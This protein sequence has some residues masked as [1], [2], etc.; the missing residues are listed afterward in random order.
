MG[1][2]TPDRTNGDLLAM[3][4]GRRRYFTPDDTFGVTP[5]QLERLSRARQ[6]E[7]MTAWFA[8][9][10]EDPA[11]STPYNSAEGGYLFIWGGPYDAKDELFNEFGSTIPE[12]RIDEAVEEVTRDGI[13]DWAPG[14]DHPDRQQAR[15]EALW[16]DRP[17]FDDEETGRPTTLGPDLD[18]II[19]DLKGGARPRY[20]GPLDAALRR[21]I[22]H[23]LDELKSL[24]EPPKPAHGGIGHNRPPPD[25]DDP[26]VKSVADIDAAQQVIRQELEKPEPN[27]LEVAKAT[28][29]LRKALEW[30]GKKVDAGVDAFVK[31]VGTEL[32]E[33]A[34][35]GLVAAGTW[36]AASDTPLGA[37]IRGV[38][39]IVT[40][41][42][43]TVTLPF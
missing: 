29:G 7:Y 8:G 10:Y 19:R 24:L 11:E 37:S 30:L 43:S 25:A 26:Q 36:L 40:N 35:A 23:R 20:G 15:D 42:L 41:W 6:L 12:D 28:S 27:A 22:L 39:A 21:D 3:A 34:T 17:D 2:L 38:I 14:H 16:D 5:S 13:V 31:K 1:G 9:R 18:D 33:H 4:R 32:G